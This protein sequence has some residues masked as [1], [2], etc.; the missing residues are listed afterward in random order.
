MKYTIGDDGEF[1]YDAPV[2]PEMDD[3]FAD[4]GPQ[5]IVEVKP[6]PPEIRRYERAPYKPS[7]REQVV[8]LI[9]LLGM[10]AVVALIC[11]GAHT[12]SNANR[13][14]SIPDSGTHFIS[15][16]VSSRGGLCSV[17]G[18]LYIDGEKQG[19]FYVEAGQYYPFTSPGRRQCLSDHTEN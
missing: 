19:M 13:L 16:F 5:P 15:T 10:C 18:D 7:K 2:N 17:G 3:P 11:S 1:I 8:F 6:K 9:M 14:P 4:L 12:W